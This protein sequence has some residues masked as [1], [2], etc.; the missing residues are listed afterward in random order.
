[1]RQWRRTASTLFGIVAGIAL[2]M[3]GR[4]LFDSMALVMD[5][6]MSSM[7]VDDLR[8]EFAQYE[9]PRVISTVRSW[10]GV[11]WAEGSLDI[12][13][14]FAH[15]GL[16]YS[17]GVAG[18]DP[19]SRQRTVLDKEGRA[20]D[21]RQDGVVIGTTVEKRLGVRAGDLVQVS[22]PAFMR[23]GDTSRSV[24]VEVIAICDEPIG[25]VA[26][27]NR[28]Y[29][30]RVF[31][32]EL[33]MPTGA[34]SGL[35]LQVNGERT[36]EVRRRLEALPEVGAVVSI[37][38]VRKMLD[39]IMAR[40]RQY[41]DYMS[42]FGAALAFSIVF[43]TV[44]INVLERANEV[45]TMRT[46]GVSRVE[47]GLMVTVEN[48]ALAVIGTVVGLPVGGWFVRQFVIAAQTEE[49]MELFSMKPALATGTY[50]LAATLILLVVLVSQ[51]PALR[52]LNRLDLAKA[53][54]ER[55]T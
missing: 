20:I 10:E 18:V 12:P 45:A 42:I 26:Y 27:M 2:I 5:T 4:G 23:S 3:T 39:E 24:E 47:V 30:W 28:N 36:E 37:T 55:S 35:R 51:W 50:M 48:L 33:D 11:V 44:T 9:D 41:V 19:E 38:E 8:V 6:L 7:F 25:T 34:V 31:K 13:V 22:L 49:Q 14:E 43:S 21:L 17:A 46:L 52:M 16:T 53:T 29:L 1:L 15:D 32:E 40:F 54:K